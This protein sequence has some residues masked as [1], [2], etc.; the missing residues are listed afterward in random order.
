MYKPIIYIDMDDTMCD[1]SRAAY[2]DIVSVPKIQYPQATFDFFR[3][4]KPIPGVIEAFH[5][6][7]QK[8]FVMI[9][10]KPSENNLLCYTDKAVWIRDHLGQEYINRLMLSCH[11]QFAKGAYL[12]DDFAPEWR[13]EMPETGEKFDGEVLHF[14]SA[15]F[16]D[17]ESI[18]EY[19][20]PE[21]HDIL[22]IKPAEYHKDYDTSLCFEMYDSKSG[23]EW[24]NMAI[25]EDGTLFDW[26]EEEAVD[27]SF[28]V[29]N[30]NLT[31]DMFLYACDNGETEASAIFKDGSEVCDPEEAFNRVLEGKRNVGSRKI[32]FIDNSAV[33]RTFETAFHT[34]KSRGWKY[35]YVAIDIH[36]TMIKPDYE[37]QAPT[38]F[39][40]MA[41]EVVQKLSNRRYDDHALHLLS[42]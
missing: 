7:E 22:K 5:K 41:K 27:W 15:K 11:K 42:R 33:C 36:G 25:L 40:P 14:G 30:P 29:E 38:E 24:A 6:L 21:R 31:F 34:S 39:Y 19:L 32:D 4:L 23:E 28:I 3:K 26:N 2:E 8:Y 12:I 17:W 37:T 13:R 35:F 1:F 16:P 18:L 9:L 20:M 10:S